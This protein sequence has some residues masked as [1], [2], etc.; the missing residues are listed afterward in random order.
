MLLD[1]VEVRRTL[2]RGYDLDVVGERLLRPCREVR[3]RRDRLDGADKADDGDD[4]AVDAD[5]ADVQSTPVQP[6]AGSVEVFA[7]V[8]PQH[9]KYFA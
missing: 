7:T 2:F 3:P 5:G 4:D 1:V 8:L 9:V 6:H